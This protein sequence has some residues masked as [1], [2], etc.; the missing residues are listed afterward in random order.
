MRT[1]ELWIKTRNNEE[2]NFTVS[3]F[4]PITVEGN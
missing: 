4:R 2:K 1:I 3:Q